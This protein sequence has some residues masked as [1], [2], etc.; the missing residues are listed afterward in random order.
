[1]K[2]TSNLT[3]VPQSLDR[4]AANVIREQIL[5]GKL[6]PDTRLLEIQLAEEFNISRGSVRS[7]LQQLTHEGLVV[8]F[9]Y[10]G[11]VVSGLSAQDA[12]ELYTLRNALEGLAAQLAA[13]AM[14]LDKAD[15]LNAAF[16]NLVEAVQNSNWAEV[17]EADFLLH[18][19]IIQLSG[20]R[21]LQEQYRIIGQQTRLYIA[22]CNAMRPDLSGIVEQHEHL[23]KAICSGNSSTAEQIAREHNVDGKALIEHLQAL[24]H[25]APSVKRN[26]QLSSS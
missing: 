23:V 8:Q 4:Q 5:N 9:P 13:E 20:H 18:Q 7:A 15:V 2:K 25:Q 1:M 24:A 17:T 12:W 19:T 11:C 14:T 26:T 16:Q 3:V 6:P 22:S 10:R 21:R